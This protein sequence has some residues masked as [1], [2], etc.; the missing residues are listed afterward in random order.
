MA[1]DLLS[2][3]TFN[4]AGLVPAVVQDVADG[5]VL[6]MAWMNAESLGLTLETGFTHFWSR[7][8]KTLW[9][10][11]E[12]SGNLQQVE[13]IRLD[14][15]GDTL[16]VKVS[17]TGP[18]CHTGS[19]TCFYRRADETGAL[20]EVPESAALGAVL[21]TVYRVVE[22][23]IADGDPSSSYVAKLFSKGQDSILKKVVE[24]AGE[25]LLA[26]KGGDA[27]ALTHEVADLMF[28]TLLT[29]AYSGVQPDDIA[30]E[31]GQRFGMSG[32]E[33]KANRGDG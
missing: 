31:L 4:D 9:K 2:E 14:C 1:N 33:E 15:D 10:K 23:R 17:Q 12:S 8:R 29:M 22:H 16:V 28:H 21:N 24:E 19:D 18:A 6:M 3:V 7:S 26:A 30:A 27:Q 13:E 11:G 32:L 20:T 5:R 25:V